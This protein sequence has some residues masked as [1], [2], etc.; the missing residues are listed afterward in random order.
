MMG[1]RILMMLKVFIVVVVLFGV[2]GYAVV[3]VSRTTTTTEVEFGNAGW[4]DERRR[5]VRSEAE[6]GV[7]GAV[8]DHDRRAV[9]VVVIRA[10]HFI[11]ERE[12][13]IRAKLCG[14]FLENKSKVFVRKT[15][16]RTNA[17]NSKMYR[18][19][20]KFR[21]HLAKLPEAMMP[22]LLGNK[23]WRK[24]EFSSRRVAELRKKA[25]E[26]NVEWTFDK[27]RKVEKFPN[28]KPMKGHKRL[29]EE[30]VKMR[31]MKLKAAEKRQEEVMEQYRA[32]KQ[33]RAKGNDA[34]LDEIFLT[35]KEK[36]LKMRT[37]PDSQK[38]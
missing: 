24:P 29:R 30:Q 4:E 6:F 25:M 20:T 26:E 27:P 32:R 11:L 22:T 2:V 16:K 8:V 7:P 37:L 10:A 17:N 18:N 12:R 14:E 28:L 9:V 33:R 35:R 19:A 23:K 36:T 38:K 5:A 34:I 21:E 13:P 1:A 3:V 15:H 31:E